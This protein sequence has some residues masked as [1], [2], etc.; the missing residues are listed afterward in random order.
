MMNNNERLK[1]QVSR[2]I[3]ILRDEMVRIAQAMFV[4]PE[5]GYQEYESSKLLSDFLKGYGFKVTNNIAGMETAFFAAYP[6]DSEGPTIALLAEY[7]ALPGLGHACGHHL[8]G[9]ASAGAAVGLSRVLADLKGKIAVVG[10]PAEEAG[11]DNAGGKVRLVE[12]GYFDLIEAAMIFHPMPLT[13]VGG[14]TNA[15]IG[16]EFEFKGKAAHAAGNPWDGIN[17]LDGVLQTY[18]AINALRQHLKEDIRIHGIV[19]HGGDAPNIV[20]EH[21]VARF[22]V[23]SEDN[24]RLGETVVKVENCARGAALATGAELNIKRFNNLYKAMNSNSVLAEVLRE[25]LERVG[26]RIEG[27]KRGKGSTDFG[28]VSGVVPACELAI[29]LGNGIVPHTKEFLNASNSE[30]GYRVM[31][32]GAKVMAMSA[33]D[34]LQSPDL[35][36]RAKEELRTVLR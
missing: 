6:Q 3:D 18:N 10:C 20:P 30:E 35:L 24:K 26:L 21:A 22:F 12:G 4:R 11:T 34:L 17:A 28:N 1:E 7:D 36:E 33:I 27:I 2:E 15:L 23:R 32:L 16:L 5:I 13:T 8:I 14:Q 31:I 9:T 29:R 19:T 25:N